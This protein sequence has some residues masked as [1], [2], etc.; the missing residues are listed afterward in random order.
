VGESNWFTYAT[1]DSEK[2]ELL[3][4]GYN[5]K[6]R[7]DKNQI[8]FSMAVNEDNI[9]FIHDTNPGNVLDS[10]DLVLVFDKG[11]NSKDNIEKVTSKMS[12]VGTA[13]ANQTEKLLDVPISKYIILV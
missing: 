11:N 12:F 1:N 9:P 6:H 5:K 4:K 13:K 8:C 7:N 3:Q 2:S 10:E